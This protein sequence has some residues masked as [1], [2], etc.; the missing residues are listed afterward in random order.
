MSTVI[1]PRS[2]EIR[3]IIVGNW[4]MNKTVGEAVAFAT[5]LLK[6]FPAAPYREV[7]IAPPFTALH[8]VAEVIRGS[9]VR[10]A[11]Q[12]MHDAVKGAYTGE[13]SGSMLSDVG[14]TYVICG[15]SERRALFGE[16]D[17]FLSRKLRAALRAGLRPIF[18]VGE[19]L[20]EREASETERV[21]ESQL[22]EGLN[23]LTADD[24]QALLIAYEPVWAIGTGKTASPA[25]AQETHRFIRGWIA[26]RYG[27]ER[28]CEPAILYG[29]S[30]TPGTIAD[31]IAQ[32]DIDG[33]LV[34]GASLEIDS[35][36]QIIGS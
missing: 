32:P 14:C 23:N 22:K 13:I 21:I 27:A 25:Q 30:V 3:P 16:G 18:C 2:T 31:L 34:G 24:I 29:G 15:H 28:T 26:G 20:R 8:A 12:N 11:A 10:L 6:A 19:S 4:K 5:H 35:F 9:F 33:A 7:V 1:P 17:A 36:V